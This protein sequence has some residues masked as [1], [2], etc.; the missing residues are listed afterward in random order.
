M[1]IRR[2]L[3][4]LRSPLGRAFHRIIRLQREVEML[5]G[6]VEDLQDLYTLLHNDLTAWEDRVSELERAKG[7]DPGGI[8]ESL[9]NDP[10]A[11]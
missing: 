9:R 5:R 6:E 11:W 8:T 7:R 3:D 10:T 2:F 4:W 1:N